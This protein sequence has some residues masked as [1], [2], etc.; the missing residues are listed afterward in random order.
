M[1]KNFSLYVILF[2]Q[3]KIIEIFLTNFFYYVVLFYE[4]YIY[5]V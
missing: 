1:L 4:I 3:I 5:I 2:N